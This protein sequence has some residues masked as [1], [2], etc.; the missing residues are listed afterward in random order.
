MGQEALE[1]VGEDQVQEALEEETE[2][3]QVLEDLVE[4]GEDQELEAL[5]V[6]LVRQVEV[7]RISTWKELLDPDL[8]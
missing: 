3:D 1:E 8:A 7:A 2:E 4:Q 6:P 5:E